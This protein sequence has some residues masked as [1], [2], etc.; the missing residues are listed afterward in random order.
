M[1][2]PKENGKA[3]PRIPAG[4]AAEASRGG[5]LQSV[6]EVFER[7]V[8]ENRLANLL[9]TGD[10]MNGSNHAED[11]VPEG[12]I[13]EGAPEP[14][15]PDGDDGESTSNLS[16]AADDA[17]ADGGVEGESEAEEASSDEQGNEDEAEEPADGL[18]PEAQHALNK[19]IG[20]EVAKRKKLETDLATAESA[21]EAAET[22]A[23]ELEQ[24]LAERDN[25]PSVARGEDPLAG[26]Q[27]PQD[28]ERAA[29]NAESVLDWCDEQLS[30]L[31]RNPQAVEA[32]LKKAGVK[33]AGEDGAEDY[34]PE[35]MEEW[36]ERTR[37]RADKT[38]RVH[39][40]R[41]QEHIKQSAE[42]DRKA[43][44]VFPWFK[45]PKSEQY[46]TAMA[47]VKTLPEI[48]RLPHWKITAGVYVLG[49]EKLKELQA[50]AAKQAAATPPK[51]PNL[52][53]KR[54]VAPRVPAGQEGR[55][56][57]AAA[58]RKRLEETGSETDLVNAIR[59]QI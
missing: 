39:V 48:K 58:A 8:D 5:G 3:V 43:A 19:R 41:K 1:S 59:A 40:P 25:T 50:A 4:V 28:L 22:R 24:Q 52:P 18:T 9:Q 26:V 14:E 11:D 49:I 12:E 35:S 6:A 42:F 47:V 16:Q 34:S 2:K 57:Q 33:L 32:Q 29:T 46:K 13:G 17:D 30:R 54:K 10:F 55:E 21:R 7:S 20:K 27:T 36:L 53:G 51:V 56:L 23:A 15:L 31:R 45:D 37:K 38:L 44:E